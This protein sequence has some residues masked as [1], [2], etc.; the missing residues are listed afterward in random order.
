MAIRDKYLEIPSD[1]IDY[2]INMSLYGQRIGALPPYNQLL[3][4][5]MVSLSLVANEIRDLYHSKYANKTT[6]LA[7][8][9]LPSDLL[10]IITTS[11]FGKS[12]VY[13]RLKFKDEPV[14]TFLGHT[15]GLG[16]FHIS[17]DVFKQIL[18]YLR[19]E[20]YD[21][22]RGYGTGPSRKLKIIEIAF[23]KLGVSHFKYHNIKR[24]I[25]LFS[26]VKNLKNVIKENTDPIWH[27]RPFFDLTE[28][29]KNRYML[30]RSKRITT[31]KDFNFNN[32][33]E[34]QMNYIQNL[35]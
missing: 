13:D 35:Q 11:A 33:F 10:F 34:R 32:F 22:K 12:S 31:W 2:W 25:Y 28:F 8:R 20:G 1:E 21:I 24:G 9:K 17:E 4:G 27:D 3:G 26:N 7:K 16:T 30:P 19:K 23:R 29:W 5:K 18:E 14:S 6:W 15:S